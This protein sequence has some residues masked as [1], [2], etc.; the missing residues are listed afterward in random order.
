MKAKIYETAKIIGTE[1]F[2]IGKF[3]QIDDF[4]FLNAG[5][6]TII[7]KFVHIASFSSIIGGGNFYMED[8][9]GLSSGCRIITGSDDFSGGGLTNPTIPSK[10]VNVTTSTVTIGRHAILGTN[11]IVFPGVTIGEGAAVGAGCIVRKDLAPWTI[12]AGTNCKSVKSRKK[13]VILEMEKKLL[14]E[15]ET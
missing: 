8:F 1:R 13:E 12:Y 7:G 2:S 11:V 4:V 15:I 10:Y 14:R 3:S 9:S 5:Q 6:E